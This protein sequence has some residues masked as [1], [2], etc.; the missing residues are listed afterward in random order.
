MPQ[1]HLNI[2]T[3]LKLQAGRQ[4]GS[5][6]DRAGHRPGDAFR[7][8]S[9]I[10]HGRCRAEIHVIADQGHGEP[11]LLEQ[12]AGLTGQLFGP[13]AVPDLDGRAHQFGGG[14]GSRTGLGRRLGGW[15]RRFGCE[16]RLGNGSLLPG[17]RLRLA[18]TGAGVGAGGFA[19]TCL[20]DSL[21]ATG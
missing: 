15:T 21:G 12:G 10:N 13:G 4:S 16:G 5:R 6:K 3:L 9:I 17:L 8:G 11:L 2:H 20:A 14:Q 1:K 18:A 7:P 19:A